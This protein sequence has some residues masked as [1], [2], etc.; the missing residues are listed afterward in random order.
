MGDSNPFLGVG[1][2]IAIVVSTVAGGIVL[3][4]HALGLN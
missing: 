4:G 3:L 2:I 1:I